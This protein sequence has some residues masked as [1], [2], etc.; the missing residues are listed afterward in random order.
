MSWWHNCGTDGDG[1]DESD[2][3]NRKGIWADDDLKCELYQFYE[4]EDNEDKMITLIKENVN[5][6]GIWT[7]KGIAD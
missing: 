1:D 2:D 5:L 4:R 3:M 6:S 7:Q